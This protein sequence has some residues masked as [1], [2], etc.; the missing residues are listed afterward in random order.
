MVTLVL[1]PWVKKERRTYSTRARVRNLWL[2]L[3]RT[4]CMCF[5]VE[6][7][8]CVDQ[9]P[10]FRCFPTCTWG[11]LLSVGPV[12]RGGI[13]PRCADPTWGVRQ[14]TAVV[15]FSVRIHARALRAAPTVF[16]PC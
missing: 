13:T 11:A 15:L 14:A 8:R 3:S 12:G 9:P 1:D 10:F 16:C 4:T 7:Q 6:G 2:S 5:Q